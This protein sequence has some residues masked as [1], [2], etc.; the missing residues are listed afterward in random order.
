[1]ESM[2]PKC[3]KKI[4]YRFTTNY[5]ECTKICTKGSEA[6]LVMTGLK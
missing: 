3:I 1:M 5:T 2:R 6:V 4:D